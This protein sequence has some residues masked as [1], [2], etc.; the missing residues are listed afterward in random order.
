MDNFY[1]EAGYCGDNIIWPKEGKKQIK[2]R[3]L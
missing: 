2:S 3:K 1:G